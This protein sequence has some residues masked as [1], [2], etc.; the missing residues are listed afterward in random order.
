MEHDKQNSSCHR[1]IS[2]KDKDRACQIGGNHRCFVSNKAH[3]LCGICLLKQA[4]RLG[5]GLF[6]EIVSKGLFKTDLKLFLGSGA[7]PI[8]QCRNQNKQSRIKQLIGKTL[9]ISGND[10]VNETLLKHG[11]NRC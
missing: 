2:D 10:I 8:E 9:K 1:E 5:H 6:K 11:G 3:L 7:Q 4:V